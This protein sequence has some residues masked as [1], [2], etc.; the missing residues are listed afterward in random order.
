[1]SAP[2][3]ISNSSLDALIIVSDV[4]VAKP[5]KKDDDRQELYWIHAKAKWDTGAMVCAISR[6]LCRQLGIT[7]NVT[8]YTRSISGTDSGFAEMILLDLMLD[9]TFISTPAIVVNEMPG[10]DCDMLIGMNVICL[11]DFN[12]STDAEKKQITVSFKPYPETLKKYK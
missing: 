3:L 7:P 11:G 4:R 12:I 2:E 6:S 10:A 5:L 8:A 1:M 9:G